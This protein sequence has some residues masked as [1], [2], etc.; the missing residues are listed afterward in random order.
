[1]LNVGVLTKCGENRGSEV[2]VM[3]VRITSM[4]GNLAK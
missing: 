1:M 4:F 3:I 2:G